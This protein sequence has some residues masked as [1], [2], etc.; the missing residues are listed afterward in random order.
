MR[1][2]TD[3]VSFWQNPNIDISDIF[4]GEEVA[5]NLKLKRSENGRMRISSD[6]QW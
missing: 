6:R 3:Y 4:E 1:R 2:T 5:K